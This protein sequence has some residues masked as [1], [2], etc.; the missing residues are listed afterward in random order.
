ML[1][2]HVGIVGA[3]V[4]IIVVSV[5]DALRPSQVTFEFSP[6]LNGE[7]RGA[8]KF[9]L[10]VNFLDG[11]DLVTGD[12]FNDLFLNYWLDDLMNWTKL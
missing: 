11:D 9:C 7:N 2:L 1:N 10:V 8:M 6:R 5:D 12:R 3:G 4:T